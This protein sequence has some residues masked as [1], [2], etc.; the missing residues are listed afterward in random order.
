MQGSNSCW[1]IS[2]VKCFYGSVIMCLVAQI[3]VAA[4]LRLGV[5]SGSLHFAVT[6]SR[7]ALNGMMIDS[8][9]LLEMSLVFNDNHDTL[10]LHFA[11]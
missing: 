4:G 9:H 8:V 5:A 11:M 1:H 10:Q 6:A 2:K 3:W 7:Q